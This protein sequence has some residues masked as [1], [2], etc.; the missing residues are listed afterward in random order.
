MGQHTAPNLNKQM[1]EW[2]HMLSVALVQ[3]KQRRKGGMSLWIRRP[4]Y[5]WRMTDKTGSDTRD[6][7]R[8][9]VGTDSVASRE[10]MELQRVL[11]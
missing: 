9:K 2:L 7:S 11:C 5:H 3:R 6:S 10:T 8:R 1:E 4:R